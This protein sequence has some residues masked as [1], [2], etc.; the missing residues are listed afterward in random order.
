MGAALFA[1]IARAT[2]I[3]PSNLPYDIVSYVDVTYVDVTYQF[4]DNAVAFNGGTVEDPSGTDI[5]ITFENYI[6]YGSMK[7]YTSEDDVIWDF[8]GNH[9]MV[10]DVDRTFQVT[11]PGNPG[12][13]GAWAKY[14]RIENTT[15][16]DAILVSVE[17]KFPG[18]DPTLPPAD[19][20]EMIENLV[21][22]V[23]SY[24]LQQGIDN[25]LDAKLAAAL[26]ALDDVNV[27]NDASAV[28]RL[29]AFI[30]EVNAQRGKKI[31]NDQANALV[32][33]AQ[34]IIDLLTRP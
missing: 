22:E 31:T 1:G 7:V 11:L 13:P 33:D 18:R 14:V 25:S 34:K 32:A 17:A 26:D 9:S 15:D 16:Y 30:S 6:E 23:A 3:G 8:R 19:P 20:V 24:N 28:N 5:V 12:D 4:P 29:E 10:S 2:V 27:N 21:I